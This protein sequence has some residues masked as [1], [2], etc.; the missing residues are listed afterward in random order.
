MSAMQGDGRAVSNGGQVK[1][2]ISLPKRSFSG[3]TWTTLRSL[4]NSQSVKMSAIFPFVGFWILFNDQVHQFL[5]LSTLSVAPLGH[6]WLDRVWSNK[7]FLVYFGLMALGFGSFL[8]QW[9]CP[10]IVKKHG[11]WSDYVRSDADAM[12]EFHIASL[13]NVLGLELHHKGIEPAEVRSIYMQRWFAEQSAEA[14]W[15]RLFTAT[16][17]YLGLAIL[18]IP[19][20]I[21]A[22]KIGT[23]FYDKM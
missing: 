9:R 1:V 23:I 5:E 12:G 13:G 7:I 8:Y 14:P 19:S 3:I 22:I 2:K 15:S 17:F 6:S 4:G 16:F 21:S 10:Y 11:D 18:A 20:I